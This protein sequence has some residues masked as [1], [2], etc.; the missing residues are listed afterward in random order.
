[1]S[2]IKMRLNQRNVDIFFATAPAFAASLP[3]APDRD[4]VLEDGVML[5]LANSV[6]NLRFEFIRLRDSF[7]V[8]LAAID[9]PKSDCA[10]ANIALEDILDMLDNLVDGSIC[11]KHQNLVS[12]TPQKQLHPQ[13]DLYPELTCHVRATISRD[14][15]P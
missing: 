1:M 10:E 7:S 15:S 6:V 11:E 2:L 14:L 4:K 8:E 9:L 13:Q 5:A 12:A 3:P